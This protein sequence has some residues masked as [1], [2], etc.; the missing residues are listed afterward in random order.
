VHTHPFTLLSCSR[1]FIHTTAVLCQIMCR[2][3][4]LETETPDR[5]QLL[6]GRD[7][8]KLGLEIH[9]P[10]TL[11]SQRRVLIVI[12]SFFPSSSSSFFEA[13]KQPFIRITQ[14]TSGGKFEHSFFLRS[15]LLTCRCVTQ[16]TD[17]D[18]TAD[19]V[20]LDSRRHLAIAGSLS[21]SGCA[22]QA[23]V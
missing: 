15:C 22:S 14:F 9:L 11:Q 8:Q 5:L 17:N 19:W 3:Y 7:S 21:P 2:R 12:I 20:Y 6:W 13:D 1:S 10:R 4:I 16:Q 18:P 23:L